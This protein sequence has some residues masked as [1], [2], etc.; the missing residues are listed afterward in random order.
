MHR[1]MAG[2]IFDHDDG[3]VD[4][5]AYR[6]N[7]RKQADAVDRVTHQVRGEER[8]EDRCWNDDQRDGRLAPADHKADQDDD[9]DGCKRQMEQ[10]LV[11]L[12]VRRLSI[13]A[14]DFDIDVRGNQRALQGINALHQRIRHDDGVR[15]G[16]LCESHADCGHGHPVLSVRTND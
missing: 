14:R 5:N 1:P 3:V 13:V 2:N 9:R 7:E 6:E 11:R 10:Q 8:E 15:T 16:A 12:V 4:Q